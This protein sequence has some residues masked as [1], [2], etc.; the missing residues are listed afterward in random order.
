VTGGDTVAILGIGGL[1]HLGAQFAVNM[2]YRTSAL[3]RGGDQEGLASRHI[4]SSAGH[5]GE[6]GAVN[7]GQRSSGFGHAA[8]WQATRRLSVQSVA[9]RLQACRSN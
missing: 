6:E 1:G 9:K 5:V 8:R 7:A 4:R 2:G 3:A